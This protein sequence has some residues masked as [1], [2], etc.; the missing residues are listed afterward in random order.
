[1]PSSGV[2]TVTGEGRFDLGAIRNVTD[3]YTHVA[4][5]TNPKAFFVGT[6]TPRRIRFAGG[7]GL[8]FMDTVAAFGGAREFVSWFKYI[9]WE[10]EDVLT[11]NGPTG[12][13]PCQYVIY[14]LRPGVQLQF[15][16]WY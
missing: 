5:L 6:T 8:S 15:V 3:V 2:Q 10:D 4:S 13:V 1:M 12:Y 16:A 9:N 14:R 11:T 7:I